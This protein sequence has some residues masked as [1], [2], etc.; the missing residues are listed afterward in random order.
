MLIGPAVMYTG[1]DRLT[2]VVADHL[3]MSI[4]PSLT[5]VALCRYRSCR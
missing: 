5:A 3:M 2:F 4:S 1:H